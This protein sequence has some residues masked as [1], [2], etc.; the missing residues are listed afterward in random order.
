MRYTQRAGLGA[1]AAKSI[2]KNVFLIDVLNHPFKSYTDM[3]LSVMSTLKVRA[4]LQLLDAGGVVLST[5]DFHKWNLWSRLLEQPQDRFLGY[6]R[7]S[8]DALYSELLEVAQDALQCDDVVEAESR[9]FLAAQ[10]LVQIPGA[11][12]G[13]GAD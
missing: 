9:L 11:T 10:N 12:A 6:L 7:H 3:C 8:D 5:G 4:L 2:G 13:P 1:D